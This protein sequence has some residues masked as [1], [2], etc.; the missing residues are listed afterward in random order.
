[1]AIKKVIEVEI[2]DNAVATQDHFNDLRNEIKKTEKEVEELSK[3][4]GQNSKEVKESVKQL[5]KLQDAYNDLSKEATDLNAT[6]EDIHKGM[7]PLT[8]RLGEA[9]DRLYELALAGKQGTREYQDLLEAASNFRKVQIQTDLV[10]DASATTLGQKLGGALQGATSSFAAVQGAMASMGVESEN[11]NEALLRVQGAMALSEGVRGVREAIPMFSMLGTTIK[12]KVVTAFSTLKGAIISTGLGALVVTV[13]FAIQKWIEYNDAIEESAKKQ[14][15]LNEKQKESLEL[16]NKVIEASE[17]QRN[18]KEGGLNQ[19]ERELKLLK[20]KG[21][22]EKEIFDKSKEILKQELSN[23]QVRY[24]SYDT[25]NKLER[26]AALETKEKI[27]DIRNDIR[28]L[29]AEYYR[30]QKENRK[31]DKKESKQH[32][33]EK[34]QQEKDYALEVKNAIEQ[35]TQ[36]NYNRSISAQ[37]REIQ[38]VQDKYFV[39]LEQAKEYN[40]DATELEIAQ[41][42]ELNEINLKYAKIKQEEEDKARAEK[43]A[44]DKEDLEDAKKLEQAK[45]QMAYSTINALIGLNDSFSAKN[46]KDA[47]RQFKINKALSLAQASIQTFQAVTGALTAGGNPIKLATGAQFVE[48]GIAAAVGGANIAK[49]AATQFGGF[50]EATGGGSDFGGGSTNAPSESRAPQFN[51][52][53]QGGVGQAQFLE[54]KPVQAFVVSGEVTSQQAL[55]R[56][57]LRNATL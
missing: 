2:K 35:A 11:L 47:R 22:T 5:N 39:L 31:Q 45:Y 16:I 34:L 9:E 57:R 8:T 10:V 12:T 46:E 6:F 49:I 55:D 15:K 37:D 20:A 4:Y 24:F 32:L 3:T 17:K 14:D 13:G 19:L 18:K 53:G 52:V 42:E 50:G 27:K 36:E 56:N 43:E 26:E 51:I 40:L 29:E 21:A 48:A 7:K 28:V 38:S 1:M 54:Q 23:L 25:N 30:N 41:K 44:K 33:D